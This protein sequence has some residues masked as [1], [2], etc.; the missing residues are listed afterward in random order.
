[1]GEGLVIDI[2]YSESEEFMAQMNI[3]RVKLFLKN[4]YQTTRPYSGEIPAVRSF[5]RP[6]RKGYTCSH[7]EHRSQAFRADDS[8]YQRE[9]RYCRIFKTPLLFTAGEFFYALIP[10]TQDQCDNTAFLQRATLTH[11]VLAVE[12]DEPVLPP[13]P[14]VWFYS[15]VSLLCCS[16][17]NRRKKATPACV[18]DL[19]FSSGI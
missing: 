9:S 13:F 7:P 17:M 19:P 3:L 2:P 4:H 6:Y 14:L 8:A 11:S 16:E 12:S 5:R 1:M 10:N 18:Q 15:T